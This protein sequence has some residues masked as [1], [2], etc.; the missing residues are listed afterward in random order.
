MEKSDTRTE[1]CSANTE[2]SDGRGDDSE[3]WLQANDKLRPLTTAKPK[4]DHSLRSPGVHSSAM[5][6]DGKMVNIRKQT[7]LSDDSNALLAKTSDIKSAKSK[8]RELLKETDRSF[9]DDVRKAPRTVSRHLSELQWSSNADFVANVNSTAD[10]SHLRSS[11]PVFVN[12]SEHQT[13]VPS[14]CSFHGYAQEAASRPSGDASAHV[15]TFQITPT[16]RPRAFPRTNP[17]YVGTYRR[18]RVPQYKRLDAQPM[19]YGVGNPELSWKPFFD[20]TANPSSNGSSRRPISDGA[21]AVQQAINRGSGSEIFW[22][23]TG[24]HAGQQPFHLPVSGADAINR[25]SVNHRPH[26]DG[27]VVP[28]YS[29]TAANKNG[30][31]VS[32]NERSA[33]NRDSSMS[34]DGVDHDGVVSQYARRKSEPDYVNVSRNADRHSKASMSSFTEVRAES[35]AGYAG[36]QA[37]VLSRLSPTAVYVNQQD[38]ATTA[39]SSRSACSFLEP[40]TD[41]TSIEFYCF[42]QC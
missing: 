30:H 26:S 29:T 8:S 35:V 5:S 23:A 10:V 25:T 16:V 6:D 24:Q 7:P 22:P 34:G 40:I 39:F 28:R 20:F 21:V 27:I 2:R 17:S 1:S 32:H 41:G 12:R 11:P 42:K 18:D 14:R 9:S 13:P 15:A 4:A 31:I 19:G 37:S 3:V 38:L 36:I 33:V